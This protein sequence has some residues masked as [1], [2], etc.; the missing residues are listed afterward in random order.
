MFEDPAIKYE[1]MGDLPPTTIDNYL[2]NSYYYVQFRV[3]LESF[4]D[5]YPDLR[6]GEGVSWFNQSTFIIC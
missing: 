5:Y 3:L 2:V 6:R 4:S 1:D